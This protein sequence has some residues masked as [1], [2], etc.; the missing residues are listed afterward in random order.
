MP[1][2]TAAPSVDSPRDREDWLLTAGVESL[3]L[4]QYDR[5]QIALRRYLVFL[6]VSTDTAEELVQE[7]FLRLYR[8]VRDGGDRSNLRAWL[9]R[10]AHNLA[11]NEQGSARQRLNRPL[12]DGA[13]PQTLA[14]AD[15]SPE[16]SLLGR[17]RDERVRGALANLTATQRECL[18][19]R[20]QGLKYREMA[21]VLDLATS[22]VAE[23]VQRGLKKLKEL[24]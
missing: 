8:H 22:T 15:E 4:E 14:A 7:A 18:V 21:E 3:V 13:L 12:D 20:A 24:L 10:V 1:A 16:E 9:Y 2:E 23:N 11:R 5:E 6:G 17:E 19:L